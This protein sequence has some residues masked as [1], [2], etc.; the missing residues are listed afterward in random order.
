MVEK[1]GRNG[2]APEQQVE[3]AFRVEIKENAAGEPRFSVR[4]LG[5][6]PDDAVRLA[7][8]MYEQLRKNVAK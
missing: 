7:S 6:A 8:E 4:A 1:D 5:D 3:P 2:Q